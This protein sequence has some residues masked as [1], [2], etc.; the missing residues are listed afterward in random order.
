MKTIFSKRGMLK[1]VVIAAAI[2]ICAICLYPAIGDGTSGASASEDITITITTKFSE[3]PIP[4]AMR[5]GTQFTVTL[6]SNITTGY[7]WRIA[8]DPNPKILKVVGSEYIQPSS[9]AMGRSGTEVWTFRAIAKGTQSVT[10]EYARPWE[11]N[12]KP[13]KSQTFYVTIQ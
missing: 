7:S 8:R 2:M 6:P 1:A 12:V 13:S 9:G 5:A 11:K 10:M 3:K 4:I